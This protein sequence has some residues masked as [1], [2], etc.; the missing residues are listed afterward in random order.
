MTESI[1]MNVPVETKYIWFPV[2]KGAGR[3]KVCIYP[4]R[5]P[6]NRL[7]EFDLPVATDCCDFYA[8]LPVE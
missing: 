5:E 2:A 4:L 8:A 1:G 7:F 3:Q 6:E